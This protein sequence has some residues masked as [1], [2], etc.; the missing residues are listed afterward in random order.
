V[1][2]QPGTAV[3]FHIFALP[4]YGCMNVVADMLT[5]IICIII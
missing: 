4:G 1:A 5:S 2:L 3:V